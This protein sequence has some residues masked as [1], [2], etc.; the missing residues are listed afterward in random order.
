MEKKR[1]LLISVLYLMVAF[2]F[3]YT[4]IT[5]IENRN[6]SYLAFACFLILAAYKY[7][8]PLKKTRKNISIIVAVAENNAIGKDNKLLCHIPEDL[9]HFKAITLNHK[10]FMGDNT[11]FSLPKGAL[12]NRENIILSL[13]KTLRIE[14]CKVVNSIEDALA[15]MDTNKEN[16]IVGGATIYNLFLPLTNKLYITKIHKSFEAD[17]FFPEISNDRWNE[18]SCEKYLDATIPFSFMIYEKLD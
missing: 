5:E 3:L 16:F 11:Y 6:L 12:P 17:T 10:I 15:L 7:F 18:V 2:V 14:G 13:D 9:K 1:K 8:F 4:A